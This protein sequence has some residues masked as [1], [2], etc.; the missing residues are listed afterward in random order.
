MPNFLYGG[1]RTKFLYGGFNWTTDTYRILF[2]NTTVNTAGYIGTWSGIGTTG[3]LGNVDTATGGNAGAAV[4]Q[5]PY[6]RDIPSFVRVRALTSTGLTVGDLDSGSYFSPVLANT[7]ATD[8]NTSKATYRS[9]IF[10]T[11][12]GE[13]RAL[14][15]TFPGVAQTAGTLQAFVLYRDATSDNFRDLVAFFDQA[16]NLP[17]PA[18]GGDITIQWATT[19]TNY[20]FKL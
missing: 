14:P 9:G 20:I 17:I 18:N 15:I 1:A 8:F 5:G 2:L 19:P 13:A 16:T 4:S 11:V 6:L 12:D 10:G 3:Y 7:P